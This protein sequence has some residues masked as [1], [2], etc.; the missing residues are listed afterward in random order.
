M[1]NRMNTLPK[2]VD[3]QLMQHLTTWESFL[4]R[5]GDVGGRLAVNLVAAILIL[6]LAVW[7]S[8]WA[9]RF[10][11]RAI[12]RLHPRR[13]PPD[14][15]LQTFLG[16]VVR[17]GILAIG[18]VAVLQQL[19]VQATSILAVLTAASLAIGLALQGALSNIAAGVMILIFRPYRV[20]D[21]IESAGRQGTVKALDL[22][23]TELA[24]ADNVKVVIPNGK[25]FGDVI[26]NYS[27]H[28]RRRVD[29]IFKVPLK[30]DIVAVLQRLRARVDADSRVRKDPPPLIEMMDLTEAYAQAAI[31]V[32]VA[33]D[34]VS[35]VR[36]DLMLSAH[37]LAEDPHAELAPPRPSSASDQSAPIPDRPRFSL[38]GPGRGR[39]S[40]QSNPQ[41]PPKA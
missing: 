34:D 13:L 23:V 32:W 7:M 27:T 5:L 22:L 26:L 4:G 19:G 24:T 9:S 1:P 38:K 14:P 10:V 8:G 30:A 6:A 3:P 2:T 17:F 41:S 28:R 16:S 35:A 18:L 36:T 25:V 40:G 39:K 12:A 31:R 11:Q 21:V 20:G 29:V 33:R 15:T 37:L